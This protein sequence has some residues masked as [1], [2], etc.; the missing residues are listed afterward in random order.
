VAASGQIR[1]A[2]DRC[3]AEALIGLAALTDGGFLYE[4]FDRSR[5]PTHGPQMTLTLRISLIP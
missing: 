3:A 5:H 4:F 2:A 1:M